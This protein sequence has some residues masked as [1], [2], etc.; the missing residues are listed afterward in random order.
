MTGESG[1]QIRRLL[2]IGFGGL[3]FLLALTGLNAL[4]ILKKNQSENER[5]REDYVYRNRTLEQLRSDVYLS[6]TYARDLLLE[7][8]PALANAHRKELENAR[9]RIQSTIATYNRI[10]RPEE[11]APFQRFIREVKAYFE[12]LRPA[13]EWNADQR[14]NLGYAFMKNF[15]LPRRMVIVQLTDQ[16]SQVNQKQLEAGNKQ[17]SQLL[18]RRMRLSGD[19]SRG[20]HSSA[21][22]LGGKRN[23]GFVTPFTT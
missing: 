18:S 22:S 3:L 21:E 1:R 12:S 5:I 13:L 16:I 23:Q 14:R 11:R 6:G 8:N 15:L 9:L 19:A 2:L 17:L 7:T 10:L 20:N 4:S